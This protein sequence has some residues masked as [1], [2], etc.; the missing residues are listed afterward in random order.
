MASLDKVTAAMTAKE[1]ENKATT[2]FSRGVLHVCAHIH[3]YE[4][5]IIR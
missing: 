2:A 1:K 4:Y 5:G 3:I